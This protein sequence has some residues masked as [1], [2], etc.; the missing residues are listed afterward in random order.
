MRKIRMKTFIVNRN[1]PDLAENQKRQIE[2]MNERIPTLENEVIVYNCEEEPFQGKLNGHYK[3][4]QEHRDESCD[5]YWF[6]HPDLS[7]AVDMN[8]LSKL[9]TVIEK[10]PWIGVISPIHNTPYPNMRK[11]GYRWHPVAVC[12]YLSLLIRQSVI[13]KIGFLNPAFKYLWGAIQEYSY[14]VYK[15]GWCIAYGDIAKM[16]HFGGTTYGQKGTVSREEYIKNAKDFASKYFVENYGESWDEEFAEVIPDGIVNVYSIH[17]KMWEGRDAGVLRA[18][19]GN[20]FNITKKCINMFHIGD[21]KDMDQIRCHLGCGER[22][23]EGWVN[24]DIDNKVKPDFVADAKDLN[25]FE[26]EAVDEIECCHLFE[27]FTYPDAVTA[28]KEWYRVLKK[29]GKLSLE[30]PNLERCIEILCK[31]EAEEAEKYAMMEIYG[32]I[33][34]IPKDGIAH[35]HKYGWTPETLTN[36]L[37][38]VRFSEIKQV[39]VTQTWRKATKYNRDMRLECIKCKSEFEGGGL[40]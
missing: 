18:A 31:K 4:L 9:L 10:N 22:K 25:M 37:R 7:F 38:K 12:D 13:E 1:T 20:A 21:S 19:L 39:P 6:N 5:Y 14:K 16:H 8:C 15:N 3:A 11:E 36:E 27:H 40:I 26:D 2:L 34:D 29:G 17:R 30:L 32:N 28:L 35:V 23:R 33:P 24:I